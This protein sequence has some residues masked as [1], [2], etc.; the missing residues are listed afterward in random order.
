MYSVIPSNLIY[1]KRLEHN[2]DN[3]GKV[4]NAKMLCIQMHM[5]MH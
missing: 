3:K 2:T 5:Q 4:Q 1:D